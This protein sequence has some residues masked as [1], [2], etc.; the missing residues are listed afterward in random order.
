[1]IRSASRSPFT[2]D[3]A[4]APHEAEQLLIDGK[5]P[6]GREPPT[7]EYPRTLPAHTPVAELSATN[8]QLL[9][10]VTTRLQTRFPHLWGSQLP[11]TDTVI[12]YLANEFLS[13]E[14]GTRPFSKLDRPASRGGATHA[15]AKQW[16][17]PPRRQPGRV[18]HR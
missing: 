11:A 9:S 6:T 14:T 18:P 15:T 17:A 3:R 8:R 4:L 10:A 12:G 5:R 13:D 16:P 7:T 1:M 2:L